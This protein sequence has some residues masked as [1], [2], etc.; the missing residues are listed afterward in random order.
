M[1]VFPHAKAQVMQL[2]LPDPKVRWKCHES[3]KDSVM[4][5]VI[6]RTPNA[7]RHRCENALHMLERLLGCFSLFLLTCERMTCVRGE[8]SLA[9]YSLLRL[10][11]R[12][13]SSLS[14]RAPICLLYHSS[15]AGNRPLDSAQ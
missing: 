1:R 2:A 13:L 9:P 6:G 7:D 3:V 10:P 8:R 14:N 15:S 5:I 4:N 11:M 12:T